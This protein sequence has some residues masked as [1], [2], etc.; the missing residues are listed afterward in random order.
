MTQLNIPNVIPRRILF[1][2]PDRAMLR[3]SPDGRWLGFI[4]P[5]DDVL[6]VWVAPMDD[7]EAAKPITH[8][9]T[10]DI[11]LYSWAHTNQHIIYL[12]DTG[13]DENWH[14]FS[15]HIDHGEAKD[16][17]PFD[18]VQ[19]RIQEVSE[20]Y[21]DEV[22]IGL[23]QRD[24]QFHDLYRVNIHTGDMTLVLEND[25]YMFI[26]TDRHFQP[27]FAARMTP[28]GGNEIFRRD[29]QEWKSF[30]TIPMEDMM[31]NFPVGLD[32]AGETLYMTDSQGRDTAALVAID[33][34]SG[35]RTVLAEN[36]QADV[37]AT[38][39]HPTSREVEAV[40]FT[41]TRKEWQI[42]DESIRGDFDYLSTVADGEVEIV[43]RT[44]QDDAW[45]VAYRMDNGPVRYYYYDRS[46]QAVRF[47]FTN[48]SELAGLP[49]AKMHSVVVK[50]RDGLDLICYYTLP[51]W[52]E[53]NARGKG[54]HLPLV[55]EIPLPTILWVHGGPWTR[56]EWGY[57]S[58][59]QLFA[60]RG[61]AVLSINYRGSTGLG[62]K[63]LNAANLEWGRKM[64]DDLIDATNWAIEEGI[65]D[66]DRIA[67]TGGSSG[68][69][70][71]RDEL[72]LQN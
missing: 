6:N 19:A 52:C 62:K 59:H 64:H 32:R 24:P 39:I 22:L 53:Q 63:F 69:F 2:N 71:T 33:I 50:A 31:T 72:G 44:H 15:V 55:P 23:N 11:R 60:N 70:R 67:I 65:A 48:Q 42:L 12:Q 61:F 34:A 29:D 57:N 18:G 4:A 14:A 8:D 21:P 68:R 30:F 17:T 7:L 56:D 10:R 20:E 46:A 41:Y 3:L 35:Q 43:S 37:D 28:D 38:M 36:A 27:R 5:L 66:R 9:T 45:L 58:I 51:S 13:G 47:L 49:L 25:S 54:Q 1:G 40:A 26:L 16:L